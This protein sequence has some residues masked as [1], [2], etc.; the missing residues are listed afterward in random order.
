MG[1]FLKRCELGSLTL[2]V[3]VMLLEALA[4]VALPQHLS[5]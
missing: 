4:S 2:I 3:A 1:I 5:G